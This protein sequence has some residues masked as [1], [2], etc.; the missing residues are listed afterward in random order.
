MSFN[1]SNTARGQRASNQ[2]LRRPDGQR[3]VSREQ[4]G[5]FGD[6][7]IDPGWTDQPVHQAEGLRLVDRQQA[8]GKSADP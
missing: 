4:R 8:G 3:R 7:V 1:R 2:F 5:E 6:R